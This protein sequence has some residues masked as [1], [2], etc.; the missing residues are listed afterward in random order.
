MDAL[1]VRMVRRITRPP[2]QGPDNPPMIAG[3][4]YTAPRSTGCSWRLAIRFTR[5]AFS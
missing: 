2:P 1:S 4:G 5:E 3:P